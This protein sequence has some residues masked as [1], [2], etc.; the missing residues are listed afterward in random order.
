MVRAL[1][2]LSERRL[3]EAGAAGR[4][5][6]TLYSGDEQ[7]AEAKFTLGLARALSG[8]KQEGRRWCEEA[9]EMARHS[10]YSRLLP[11]ALMA[12]AEAL[13]ESGDAQGARATALQAQ[14]SF[15]RA[16]HQESEWRAWLLAGRAC[17]RASD[18]LNARD[19]AS[20]A[21]AA[22]SNLKETWKIDD[23]SDYFKRPDIKESLRHLGQL[24]A[25]NR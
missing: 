9:V 14:E 12:L 2:E 17:Q 13:I 24:M 6:L 16:G 1:L 3:R 7:A 21:K 25:E 18:G 4:Q 5:A 22:L 15:A 11:E 20:R 10:N 23:S 19:Y 8:A